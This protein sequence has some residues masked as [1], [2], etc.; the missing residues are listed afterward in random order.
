MNLRSRVVNPTALQELRNAW[1]DAVRESQPYDLV[2]IHHKAAQTIWKGIEHSS[3][4]L[5]ELKEHFN[6]LQKDL[7]PYH[8]NPNLQGLL[9]P[10]G[11]SEYFIAERF[12]ALVDYLL[13][14]P[15]REENV[16]KALTVLEE[17]LLTARSASEI[18]EMVFPTINYNYKR[19]DKIALS[20]LCTLLRNLDLNLEDS[21]LSEFL[22]L[23]LGSYA[24]ACEALSGTNLIV[25]PPSRV[26]PVEI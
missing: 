18:I 21:G 4:I 2:F 3:E 26:D 23:K 19:D 12:L 24:N 5:R 20:K 14:N 13:T 16:P 9:F 15:S 8:D 1:I 25:L 6:V 22:S 17:N 10:A 7:R 11:I